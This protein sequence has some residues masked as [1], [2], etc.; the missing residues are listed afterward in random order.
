MI[1]TLAELGVVGGIVCVIVGCL[2]G[3]YF[4]VPGTNKNT[5]S[6]S[7]TPKQFLVLLLAVVTLLAIGIANVA[8]WLTAA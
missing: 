7:D 8:G 1:E 5:V 3:Y 4:W 2:L 6:Y